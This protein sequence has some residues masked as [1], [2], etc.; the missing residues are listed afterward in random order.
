ML[1]I[2]ST[3]SYATVSTL[4]ATMAHNFFSFIMALGATAMAMHYATIIQCNHQFHVPFLTGPSGTGKTTSL[5]SGLSLFGAHE[6][7]FYSRGTKEKYA[8]HCCESSFPIG[9]DDPLSPEQTGQL[10]VDL[11]NG[12]KITTVKHNNIK[13]LS[14]VIV[15]ANFSMSEKAR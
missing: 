5:R 12:A 3:V 8:L 2:V 11:C 4:E 14:T 6:T 9:C 10:L 7:R 1:N 13:P 15:S